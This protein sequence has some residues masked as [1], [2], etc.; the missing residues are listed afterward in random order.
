MKQRTKWF[1]PFTGAMIIAV[2]LGQFGCA[3]K[4]PAVARTRD[5][6]LMLDDLYKTVIV[7]VTQHYVTSPAIVSAATAGKLI[8]AEMKTKGWH[9]IR[10]LGFTDQITNPE[11]KPADAFEKA[12]K[13][14]LLAGQATYEEVVSEGGKQYLR[15]ATA[16]PVVMEKC[17]M[18][19]SNFKD[20]KGVIG[21]LSYKVPLVQ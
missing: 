16:V 3:A 12:A 1:R 11:N 8:F 15:M 10:L 7:L 9:D 5:Q 6:V 17:V 19:H 2:M 18:C 20:N 4:D 13:K 21:S 14:S